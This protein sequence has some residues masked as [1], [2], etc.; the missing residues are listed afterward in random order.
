MGAPTPADGTS[1]H[2]RATSADHRP[3]LNTQQPDPNS[4]IATKPG[5]KSVLKKRSADEHTALLESQRQAAALARQEEEGDY[6]GDLDDEDNYG[7]SKSSW[8]M[9][10]LTLAIGGYVYF[11]ASMVLPDH[12]LYFMHRY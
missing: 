8:Y 2:S 7:E 6:F 4:H 3:S 1:S 5:P 12:S 11:S 9:I 10:L